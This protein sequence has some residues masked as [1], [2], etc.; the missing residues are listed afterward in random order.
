MRKPPLANKQLGQ[1]WLTHAASLDAIAEIAEL[2]PK[3]VVLEIGPGLGTLTMLLVR[4]AKQVIAVELDEALVTNLIGVYKS[5]PEYESKLRV[6]QA[7]I[8][9]FDLTQLPPG[10]KI[11]ANIPYYLTAYLLRLL[12]DTGHKPTLA[13]L[14]VQKEVAVRVAAQAGKM[15]FISVA[16]QF[17]Y[18]VSLSQVISAKL[19]VPPPKVDSQVLILRC[20][21]KP[22]YPDVDVRQFFHLVKAGFSNRR[23]TLLN[24]LSGG[25]HLSK[26]LTGEMLKH[27]KIKPNARAQE[28]SLDDWHRLYKAS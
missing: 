7:D 6:V 13:V 11:V 28:L 19:F 16:V 9:K 17:Y 10:Y 20:R 5:L 25:L 26:E 23:K 15:S 12:T 8:R 21:T 1:H 18:H 27:T 3:D 24:S 2:N 14:L 22:L 4:G